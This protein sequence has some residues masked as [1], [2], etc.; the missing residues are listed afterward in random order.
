MLELAAEPTPRGEQTFVHVSWDQRVQER[1]DGKLALRHSAPYSDPGSL[2]SMCSWIR[3]TL[4]A[5]EQISVPA[6]N[7]RT[8]P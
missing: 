3:R 1:A 6:S 8:A 4:A 2:D 5:R 7:A